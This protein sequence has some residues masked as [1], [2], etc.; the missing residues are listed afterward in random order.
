MRTVSI[1]NMVKS[2]AGMLGTAD[3]SSWEQSFVRSIAEQ[4]NQGAD[5]SKLS[6]KQVEIVDTI[7]RKHF[8]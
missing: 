1:G 4:S 8:A 3:L 6:E 7:F 5:T 2:I